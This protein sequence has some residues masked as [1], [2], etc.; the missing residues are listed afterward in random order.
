MT[1]KLMILKQTLFGNRIFGFRFLRNLLTSFENVFKL[2]LLQ[3]M[4]YQL[5]QLPITQFS[6]LIKILFEII[7]FWASMASLSHFSRQSS[8]DSSEVIPATSLLVSISDLLW[9]TQPHTVSFSLHPTIILLGVVYALRITFLGTS[10]A[11]SGRGSLIW[12][13]HIVA[14]D[15]SPQSRGRMHCGA[16]DLCGSSRCLALAL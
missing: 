12:E 15:E 11:P 13:N 16:A 14:Y 6:P 7:K 3:S 5:M 8:S 10:P 2:S 9:A 4:N 1:L